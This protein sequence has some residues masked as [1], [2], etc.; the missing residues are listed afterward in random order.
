MVVQLYAGANGKLSKRP[1][2][3]WSDSPVAVAFSKPYAVA[4]LPGH[5]EA[6]CLQSEPCLRTVN[7]VKAYLTMTWTCQLSVNVPVG[8]HS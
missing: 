4:V 5:I 6:S 3:T 7:P 1:G 2:I 8:T